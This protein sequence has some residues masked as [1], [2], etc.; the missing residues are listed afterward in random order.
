MYDTLWKMIRD[1]ARDGNL[2]ALVDGDESD[3]RE[4]LY[5]LDLAEELKPEDSSLN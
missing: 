1:T 3:P 4:W 5:A 2:R